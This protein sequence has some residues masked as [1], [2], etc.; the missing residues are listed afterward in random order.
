MLS[1]YHGLWQVEETFR[2]SKHDLRVRPIYHWTPARAHA[3]IAISFMALM[4]VRHLGYRAR[5]QYKPLSPEVVRHALLR[6][7]YGIVKDQRSAQR[8]AIPMQL[9]QVAKKLYWMMGVERSSVPF[10]MD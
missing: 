7:Q 6:A 3:H 4:C 1:H 5:L 2:I 10:E 8:Y 9:S